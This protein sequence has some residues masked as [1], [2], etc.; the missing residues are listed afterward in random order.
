MPEL[1]RHS[2]RKRE[3]TR[4]WGATRTLVDQLRRLDYVPKS[5]VELLN[6][7]TK[8]E[9]RFRNM[10]ARMNKRQAVSFIRVVASVSESL[11]EQLKQAQAAKKLEA[12]VREECPPGYRRLVSQYY[13]VLSTGWGR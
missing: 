13:E 7:A 11:A 3:I 6:E 12:G 4:L 8:T 1:V 2:D 5:S 10:F 9:Y